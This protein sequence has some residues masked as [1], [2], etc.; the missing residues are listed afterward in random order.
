MAALKEIEISKIELIGWNPR[1]SFDEKSLQELAASIKEH[2]ILE[3]LV[4]RQANGAYQLV[5]GERRLRAAKLAGF[6]KVP[7]VVKDLSDDQV[8][9]LMLIENLQ[10]EDLNP[11]EEAQAIKELLENSGLTQKELGKRLGKSQ[12][13]IANRLRLLQAPVELKDLVISRKISAKHVISLLP[14]APYPVFKKKVLPAIKQLTSKGIQPSVSQIQEI[15]MN[16]IKYDWKGDYVLNLSDL[17]I[18]VEKLRHYIDFSKC[19]KCKHKIKYDGEE[20]C[21]NRSCFK[22]KINK[23]KH[24]RRK[25]LKD[26][27]IVDTSKLDWGSYNYLGY[28]VNFD[29]SECKNC[30]D[31]K[32][33]TGDSL[34]CI[35]TKCFEK[36]A[37]EARKILTKQ[38]RENTKKTF[39]YLDEKLSEITELGERELRFILKNLCQ[40]LWSESVKK[41]LKPWGDVESI[42][43]EDINKAMLRLIITDRIVRSYEDP[44]VDLVD[45]ILKELQE[46]GQ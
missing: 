32:R 12:A 22:D 13:W 1:K 29:T 9:E 45:S 26:K 36:K 21:L 46:R 34:I 27:D 40:L 23:A 15:S 31:C 33:T 10:R 38:K 3:P 44:S 11:L 16:Q 28:G 25:D 42:P 6:E 4:V 19:E 43:A 41:G 30:K 7:V 17:P 8:K 14:I 18:E 39:K 2:G 37:R 35:N 20:Y 5:A 24:K